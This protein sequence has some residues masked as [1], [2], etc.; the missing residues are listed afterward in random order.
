VELIVQPDA[1]DVVREM[2]VGKGL[3]S[4]RSDNGDR[5]P[6]TDSAQ[7]AEI[8]CPLRVISRHCLDQRDC[9]GRSG[10][11][12]PLSAKSGHRR[13]SAHAVIVGHWAILAAIRALQ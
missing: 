2:C 13:R 5:E 11:E 4:G 1:Q 6:V 9:G 10:Q 3:S 8:G 7:C 12:C